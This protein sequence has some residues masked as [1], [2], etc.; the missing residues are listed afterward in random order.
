MKSLR[1][2]EWQYMLILV[3]F[4]ILLMGILLLAGL[5]LGNVRYNPA[6][7]TESYLQR[8]KTAGA[9]LKELEQAIKQG[10]T[11]KV[12]ELSGT[13]WSPR[14]I[15]STPN[16]QFSMFWDQDEKYQDYLYFD[17]SNYHRYMFHIKNVDG[18]FVWVPESLYY[19]VDS[20]RWVRTFFP[21]LAIWWI[22]LFLYYVTKKVYQSLISYR[23]GTID[24]K[25]I[26]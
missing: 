6:F 13:K 19:Y 5:I 23:P 2:I 26:K 4:P 15:N 22:V 8:Y 1:L 7:F 14:A 25:I 21:I 12:R 24:N 18:R 11:T 10:D 3:L 20:G 17:I 16:L 9:L